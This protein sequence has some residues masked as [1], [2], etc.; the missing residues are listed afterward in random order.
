M[1]DRVRIGF[2]GAGGIAR[3]HMRRLVT[4]PEAE[5]VAFAEP[6]ESSMARM[7]EAFPEVAGVPVFADH[8]EMLSSVEMDA[9]EILSPH[10]QHYQQG[11]D[12]FAAGKHLLMEKPMVCTVAHARP[13]MR[14]AGDSVFMI[15]YQRHFQGPYIYIREQ[16]QQGALGELQYVAALQA[17]NWLRNTRGKWRQEK[18]LSGGG[19]LNDSGSHLVDILLW[20][21]GLAA[22][23]VFAYQGN[24][25]TEVDIDSALSLRF[26]NGAQGTLSIVGD[27][28][29]W[30]E[31]FSIWGSEGVILYRNGTILQR[32]YGQSEMTEVTELPNDSTPDQNFIDAILG[33]D[34]VRVP[35]ECG[36]RVIELT[37]AAWKS[38]ELGRAVRVAELA[39]GT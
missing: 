29:M 27:S 1:T 12:V 34:E 21:T 38:A 30:W 22:E 17:Q 10:T 28:P 15:S 33:R 18:A 11:L 9:V 31:E 26:T 4:I 8:R 20:T 25:N 6:S 14:A 32:A 24:Y 7:V 35:P 39:Q 3:S 2:I 19:Q 5:V 23:S 16:I 36:L 13:L 37:E